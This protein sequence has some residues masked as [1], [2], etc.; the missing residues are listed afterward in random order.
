MKTARLVMV[1]VALAAASTAAVAF[2]EQTVGGAPAAGKA[3]AASVPAA[4]QP[5]TAAPAA[6]LNVPAA[7]AARPGGTEIRI[8]GLGKLGVIPKVDFGLELLYGASEPKASEAT[9]PQPDDGQVMIR[10]RVPL[11]R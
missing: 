5:A 6:G 1:G 11:G 10:G 3:P 4:A 7:P 8:P 9:R 2:Q